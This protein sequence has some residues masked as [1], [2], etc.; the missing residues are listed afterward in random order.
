MLVLGGGG[1]LGRRVVALLAE[2]HAVEVVVLGRGATTAQVGSGDVV[3]NLATTDP[4]VVV[5]WV[6]AGAGAAG[7]LDAAPTDVTHRALGPVPGGAPVV[8]GTGWSGGVGEAVAVTAAE[9]L[10]HPT[11]ADVT[12]WVPSRR[13]LLP[14]ATP[15]ERRDLWRAAGEPV[16]V[17][18]DGRVEVESVAAGRRLAWFPRPVGPH[19]AVTVPGP[20]WWTLPRVVPGLATV[21]SGLALRSSSAEVLQGLGQLARRRPRPDGWPRL[22]PRRAADRGTAG[23]R[24]AVVAEVSDPAGD[25]ARG[26]AY[27]RDRH[28]VTAQVVAVVASRLARGDVPAGLRG[29]VGTAELLDAAELL[30]ELAARTDLRWSVTGP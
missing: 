27:G 28:E 26:W 24:W 12:A 17:L 25:L 13:G 15:R 20:H 4:D 19:H 2:R 3:C 11:R 14:G 22:V 21:R 9:R 30:D 10:E 1:R 5:P 8:L 18:V 6:H 7:Y 23:E 29:A 16:R